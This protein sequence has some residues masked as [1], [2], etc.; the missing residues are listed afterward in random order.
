[1]KYCSSPHVLKRLLG[2]C[3]LSVVLQS[4]L[5]ATLLV[6]E[7]F[8]GYTAGTFVGQTTINTIGLTGSYVS[9]NTTATDSNNV[10]FQTTGLSFGGMQTNG[11]SIFSTTIAGGATRVGTV[12]VSLG[13]LAGPVT[14]SLYTSYLINFGTASRNDSSNVVL[15]VNT[16]P[17]ATSGRYFA[18]TSDGTTNNGSLNTA[19]DTTGGSPTSLSQSGTFL[20][21]DE[22]TNVGN[23]TAVT[24]GTSTEWIVSET[25]YNLLM[26]DGM[27]TTAELNTAG[28]VTSKV[29]DTSTTGTWNFGPSNALQLYLSTSVAGTAYTMDEVRIGTTLAD[30][31]IAVPESNALTLLMSA[32][33][34][35]LGLHRQKRR[36]R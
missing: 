2:I 6:Y 27:I 1:M 33:I 13:G 11:G 7:G 34:L 28:A 4:P 19:Y 14:G 17:S 32:G 26:A 16:A 5:P 9:A 29:T 20:V 12:G 21:I 22:F 31:A 25:Q 35:C 8:D 23:D 30:V 36:S 18:S 15:A 24:T 10:K 3:A